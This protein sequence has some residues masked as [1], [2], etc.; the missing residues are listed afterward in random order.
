M[1]L[2]SVEEMK[3]RMDDQ[4]WINKACRDIAI[5]LGQADPMDGRIVFSLGCVPNSKRNAVETALTKTLG[6]LG[7][8]VRTEQHTNSFIPT[9]YINWAD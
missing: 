2:P 6:N 8:L 5:E 4:Y 1:E 9:L 7:Y 3:C